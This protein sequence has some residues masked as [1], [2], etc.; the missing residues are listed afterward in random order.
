MFP[1]RE[2]FYIVFQAPLIVCTW[3]SPNRCSLQSFRQIVGGRRLF[4]QHN[5]GRSQLTVVVFFQH[6]LG[7]SVD[8]RRFF[9]SRH[10]LGVCFSCENALTHA[11][12]SARGTQQRYTSPR[13]LLGST[14]PRPPERQ[15][16]CYGPEEPPRAAH[17]RSIEIITEDSIT[18][19]HIK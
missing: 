8:D 18:G 2:R 16:A 13:A 11:R 12:A 14:R 15:S 1:L 17:S 4:F 3:Y 5:F 19:D 10:A 9:L 7:G 6:N